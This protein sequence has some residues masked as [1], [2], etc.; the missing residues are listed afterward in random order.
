MGGKR[1]SEREAAYLA[2]IGG[3][4][5]ARAIVEGGIRAGVLDAD[6]VIVAD[7]DEAKHDAFRRAVRTASEAVRFLEEREP[8]PGVGQVLLAVKPQMLGAVG[9]E[10]LHEVGELDRVVISILAGMPS[11]RVR[12]ELGG[13]ARVIRVMPN[14]PAAIGM[15]MTAIA[16]SPGVGEGSASDADRDLCRS[17]F[18]AIGKTVEI[19]ESMIDAF[20]GVAGSGP[21][22]VFYL[23][24]AMEAAA[25]RLGF[26]EAEA[27]TIVM[28][29]V[30]G[31]A[32]L[33]S[34]SGEKPQDLRARVTSRGGTTAAATGVMDEAGFLEMMI[35]AIRAARDRG[36]E[37]AEGA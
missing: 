25:R 18:E 9:R 10:L 15:G 31:A 14:T 7:P 6:R 3:G 26:E 4:N 21:A 13:K 34:E 33:L 28:Q 12:Q 11:G 17:L 27:R 16:S 20:T 32:R 22:Y 8:E 37:L 19:P 35:A 36:A 2:V 24:E 30:V 5:M 29:T 23:A 1:A